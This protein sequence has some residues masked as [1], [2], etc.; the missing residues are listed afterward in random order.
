[1]M[2]G[3]RQIVAILFYLRLFVPSVEPHNGQVIPLLDCRPTEVLLNS[4]LKQTKRDS[5]A[6]IRHTQRFQNKP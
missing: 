2:A 1:M 4:Y 5:D 3:R 6:F